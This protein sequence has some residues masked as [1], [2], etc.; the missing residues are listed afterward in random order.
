[1]C[2]QMHSN[3]SLNGLLT[4][5]SMKGNTEPNSGLTKLNFIIFGL[6]FIVTLII[7]VILNSDKMRHVF[8]VIILRRSKIRY[9]IIATIGSLKNAIRIMRLSMKR[10]C[11][12][13]DILNRC[14]MNLGR[15]GC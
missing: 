2:K 9:V 1:M 15:F 11:R 13:R 10:R 5:F 8:N 6:F 3:A 14:S 4:D 7:R 12:F